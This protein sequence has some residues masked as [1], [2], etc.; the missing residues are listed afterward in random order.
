MEKHIHT[1][2][3]I[4]IFVGKLHQVMVHPLSLRLVFKWGVFAAFAILFAGNNQFYQIMAA[5]I[6]DELIRVYTRSDSPLN[7]FIEVTKTLAPT[8]VIEE[9]SLDPTATPQPIPTKQP[10]QTTKTIPEDELWQALTVYRNAHGKKEIGRAD[11]L[12]QYARNRAS[13]LSTR[14]ATNPEDPLDAHAGFKRD[15]DSG[16][17]FEFTGFS[18]VG[19][20][21]AY[22]PAFTTGTQ[23]IEW[24]WDTS[25]GHRA[26]QLS[27]NITHG[28]ISGIHP[29][30]VGIFGS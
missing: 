8:I 17:V 5:K 29:I 6:E 2:K 14:L 3:Y 25:S 27:D 7:T 26:L 21:L 20:N 11:K 10:A 16:H 1:H 15:A 30:Y 19:E 28:C 24:G 9:F 13:E 12:C 18:Y 22:T 4:Q 23:V